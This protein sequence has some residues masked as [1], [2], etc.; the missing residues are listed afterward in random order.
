M[1][2][3]IY[4]QFYFFALNI[5][6]TEEAKRLRV[7]AELEELEERKQSINDEEHLLNVAK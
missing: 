3:V 4:L 2:C 1:E 7:V 6:E 5:K